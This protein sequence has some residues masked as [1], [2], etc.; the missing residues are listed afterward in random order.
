[1]YCLLS[2]HRRP[3][4]MSSHILIVEVPD[5]INIE[6]I[7][8]VI[9]FFEE[10][11]ENL[12]YRCI[13]TTNGIDW[14]LERGAYEMCE[15]V[16]WCHDITAFI[17]PNLFID[18]DDEGKIIPD[19]KYLPMVDKEFIKNMMGYWKAKNR[20]QWEHILKDIEENI[21]YLFDCIPV[22]DIIT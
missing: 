6:M 11:Q 8:K 3:S 10:G 15:K 2:D 22:H 19:F 13:G 5:N 1:M 16:D 9:E 7:I 21:D 4:S 17:P 14:R 20:L 18:R 12:N